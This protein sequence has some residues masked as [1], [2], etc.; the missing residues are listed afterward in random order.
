MKECGG[1]RGLLVGL[2]FLMVGAAG[3]SLWVTRDGV[4]FSNNSAPFVCAARTYLQGGAMLVADD[5]GG[6]EPLRHWPPLYPAALAA[7]SKLTG[8]VPAAARWLDALLFPLSICLLAALAL[9]LR[10]SAVAGA[11]VCLLFTLAPVILWAYVS[12][13]SEALCLMFW[14]LGLGLLLEYQKRQSWVWLVAAAV[15]AAA[16]AMTRYVGEAHILAGVV[17]VLLFTT[18]SWARK[19]V[20]AAAYGL[21]AVAPLASWIGSWDHASVVADR[22]PAYYGLT[23]SQIQK[24]A[25]A[26]TRWVIPLDGHSIFKIGLF[27]VVGL[28]A[29]ILAF[30][31]VKGWRRQ[32]RRPA[33]DWRE[34]AP[35]MLIAISLLIYQAVILLTAMFLDPVMD[36]SERMQILPFVFVLLLLGAGATALWRGDPTSDDRTTRL[37]AGALAALITLIYACVAVFWLRH[38][39]ADRLDFNNTAWHHSRAILLAQTRYAALPL[40]TNYP[41]LLYLYTE[42]TD[43]HLVPYTMI[44]VRNV[45]DADFARNFANLLQGLA[46]CHGVIVYFKDLEP[47]MILLDELKKNPALRVVDETTDAVFLRAV[48]DQG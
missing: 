6:L 21:I 31:L 28:L 39:R 18:G 43:L 16:V 42:R 8:D 45:A 29:A 22:H 48:A 7:M 47:R 33:W 30:L 34:H 38:A 37:C 23:L 40:Y 17:F 20:R 36:L 15:V 4:G 1:S 35:V 9:R 13:M 2:V 26:L 24:I 14:L 5:A 44:H 41:G 32:T 25:A 19:L 12:A 3:A 27:A 46:A 11:A 10:L